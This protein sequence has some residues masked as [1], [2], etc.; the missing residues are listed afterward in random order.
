MLPFSLAA[1][2]GDKALARAA[3]IELAEAYNAATAVE[4]ELVGRILGFST[5]AMDNLRVSM[6]PEMSDTK[7]LRYRSNAVALSRAGEQCRKILEVIQT[8][9]DTM[10]KP[11]AI[12]QPKIAPAPP[13]L[14][15]SPPPKVAPAPPPRA[16]KETARTQPPVPRAIEAPSSGAPS[17]FPADINVM[18]RD[19]REMLAAFSRNGISADQSYAAFPFIPETGVM[20]DTAVKEALAEFTGHRQ[21]ARGQADAAPSMG[22]ETRLAHPSVV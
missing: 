14:K 13:P 10:Q 17:L 15:V 16:V 1:A 4:L 2:G 18:K 8:K 22:V 12:P 6:T 21:A 5:V 9:R 7:V 3:I 20:I 11:V 19:A